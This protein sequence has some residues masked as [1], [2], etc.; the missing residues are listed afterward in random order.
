MSSQFLEE[1]LSPEGM[2]EGR[3]AVVAAYEWFTHAR[4]EDQ[5]ETI[6]M[7]G[8]PLSWPGGP[9]PQ[10]QL[11]ALGSDGNRIIC[12]STYPKHTPLL[13]NKGGAR[14]FKLALHRDAMPER[15]ALDCTFSGTY[16][17]A[18]NLRA[19]NPVVSRG[20]IFLDIVRNREVI[21]T[22]DTIPPAVLRV[23]PQ[24]A[25]DASPWDWPMLVNTDV[26]DVAF[27]EPDLVGNVSV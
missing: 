18:A 25:P 26:A 17:Q 24:T 22:F 20:A 3:A 19:A 14:M 10:I 27:F 2:A 12:L 13:L 6:K 16:E 23:C 4:T 15:V 21:V 8:I 9:V 5:F 1:L 11:D 7:N